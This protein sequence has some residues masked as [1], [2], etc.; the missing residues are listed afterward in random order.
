MAQKP[1]PA[2]YSLEFD[3]TA[4]PIKTALFVL[5]VICWLLPG[6]VGH[7]PWKPQEPQTFGVAFD[8]LQS[9]QWIIPTLAGEPFLERPPLYYWTAALFARLFSPLFPLHDGAR[10]ASGFYVLLAI[11]LIALTATKMFGPRFGRV[12]AL[13]FIGSF[14]LL[15]S[16]HTIL[17]DTAVLAAAALGLYG[18]ASL[19]E[20]V[21]AAG[22]CLGTAVGIAFLANGSMA[23]T[24]V[25]A[26]ALTP[27]LLFS[28]WRTRRVG[29]ALLVAGLVAIP[30]LLWWPIAFYRRAP[31][32]ALEWLWLNDL[33]DFSTVFSLQTINRASY[34]LSLLPWYA[35]PALPLV[36]VAFW[37]GRKTLTS[38]AKIQLLLGAF[39]GILV[40]LCLLGERREVNALP[41]LLPLSLLCGSQID[42]FKRGATSALDWFGMMGFGLLAGSMWLGWLALLY[43]F[44]AP[45]AKYLQTYLPG[46]RH[47][48][49]LVPF[50]LASTLS[51]L[52]LIS[53]TR[54][55]ISNRRA[56][57][58]WTAG[59]TMFWML[60]MTLWLPYLDEAKSY[61]AMIQ[62]LQ[63]KLPA[64]DRCVASRQLGL[65]QRALLQYFAGL[66]TERLERK[67]THHCDYLLVQ[68]TQSKPSVEDSRDWKQVWEGSRPG[69]TV[70]R[71]QL[72]KRKGVR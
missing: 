69:D 9:G 60:A 6:L 46:H 29:R 39:L 57:V 52:W 72:Y 34:Y 35:W 22:L 54:S 4:T 48:F 55:R 58:N 27:F 62:S 56:I 70:E 68:S 31:Q 20:R 49:A 45:L 14:G 61:R 64:T 47:E 11:C 1:R 12:T 8:I 18:L 16:A 17:A 26:M 44:P 5:V 10:L 53:I 59:I 24:T 3:G 30:L 19:P 40:A 42:G 23:A 21:T 28:A 71:Y 15:I 67:A 38:D 13:I 33:S 32:L 7:D 25:I 37:S 63:T 66:R 2:G 43:G 51:I 41:L 65:P 50:I 36:A